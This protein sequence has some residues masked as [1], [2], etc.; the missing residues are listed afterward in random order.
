MGVK[1]QFKRNG[2]AINLK[3]V[4]NEYHDDLVS[5]GLKPEISESGFSYSFDHLVNIGIFCC[6]QGTFNQV[7]LNEL[8]EDETMKVVM[9][10]YLNGKYKF[11]A[12]R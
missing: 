9:L 8:A 5:N 6:W 1:Y 10:D 7:R 3:E 4:E 11:S 2:I 12:W